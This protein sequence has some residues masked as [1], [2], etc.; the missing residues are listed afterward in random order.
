VNDKLIYTNSRYMA[1]IFILHRYFE[2]SNYT[3]DRY[4]VLASY[5]GANINTPIQ[6]AVER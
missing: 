1:N 6:D 3:R 4:K 5:A 2:Q